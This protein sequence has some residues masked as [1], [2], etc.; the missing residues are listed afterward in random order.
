MSSLLPSEPSSPAPSIREP[1]IPRP[2]NSLTKLQKPPVARHA[3]G[4]ASLSS[5]ISKSFR[6]SFESSRDARFPPRPGLVMDLPEDEQPRNDGL[7]PMPLRPE[8][9]YTRLDYHVA[10]L[11]RLQA[12]VVDLNKAKKG[13]D[14]R[15]DDM[16]KRQDPHDG[17]L[18]SF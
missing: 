16:D 12:L 8:I 7:D 4:P 18:S 11:K 10:E 6:K 5:L 1:L 17:S 13:V 3:S 2:Q 15:L 14:A 9:L